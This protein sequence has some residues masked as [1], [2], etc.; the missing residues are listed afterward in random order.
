MK[1]DN[2]TDQYKAIN[3]LKK[4]ESYGYSE[5]TVTIANIK[6]VLAP[7]TAGEI[8]DVFE[9]SS[10]YNDIDAA[11]KV[12]KIETLARAIIAVGDTKF[13]PKAFLKEKRDVV[14]TFGDELIDIMF[15]EYCML[16]KTIKVSVEKRL[17]DDGL[18]LEKKDGTKQS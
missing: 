4:L 1:N 18:N 14:L 5:R 17:I 10:S 12:L 6:M 7:L 13:N 3:E 2:I 16:D 15:N 11:V 8:I 9:S